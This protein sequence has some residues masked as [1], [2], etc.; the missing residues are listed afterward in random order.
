M[1]TSASPFKRFM[2]S[3]AAVC[4][5]L[6]PAVANGQSTAHTTNTGTRAVTD[7]ADARSLS[8]IIKTVPTNSQPEAPN[9]PKPLLCAGRLQCHV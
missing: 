7:N 2:Q 9:T 6:L 1:G 5:D 4:W 8:Q 3:I